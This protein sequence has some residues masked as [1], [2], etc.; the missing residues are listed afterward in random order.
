MSI[1]VVENRACTPIGEDRHV[2]DSIF[3]ITESPAFKAYWRTKHK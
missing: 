2:V 1:A 3:P